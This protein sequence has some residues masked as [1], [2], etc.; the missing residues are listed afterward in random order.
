MTTILTD[1]AQ[2]VTVPDMIP[3][4]DGK[5]APD[6][7]SAQKHIRKIDNFADNEDT[8][9]NVIKWV[10]AYLYKFK[11]QGARQEN[12]HD[13]DRA[14]E[15][16]RASANRSSLDSDQSANIEKTT[17]KIQSATYYSDI[18]AITANEKIVV[19]GNEQIIPVKFEPIPGCPDYGSG[20]QAEAEGERLSKYHNALLAY[21]WEV[22][23]LDR[24]IAN[25]LWRMN[26]YGNVPMEMVWDYKVEERHIKKPKFKRK[27]LGLGSEDRTQ[28]TGF[29]WHKEDVT[30]ADWPRLVVYDMKDVWFDAM[31]DDMQDQS[32]II[33][34]F[35]KQLS[36]VWTMQKTGQFMNVGDIKNGHLY[37]GEQI[38][39]V[40]SDRQAN[41]NES[42][43]SE[44]P[45]TLV[46]IWKCWIRLPVDPETG[47]WD[48]EKNLCTWF[49]CHFA[50]YLDKGNLVCLEIRPNPHSCGLIP[51]NLAH[52]LEDDKGAFHL[53]Y[54]TLGKSYYAQEMTLID[55]ANDNVRE[56][57]RVPLLVEKGSLDIKNLVF[58]P[59]GNRIWPYKSGSKE[60]TELKIQ[61]TT[62]TTIPMLAATEERRQ[63]IM[64]TNKAF[65]GEPIGGR[66]SA[67]GYLGTLDQALKPALE[68]VKFKAEQI[69]PFV[70]FWVKELYYDFGNP[71]TTLLITYEN[72]QLEVKPSYLYGDF[73]IRVSSVKNFQDSAIKR[74]QENELLGQVLPVAA[75]LGAIDAQGSKIIFKQI[76]QDRKIEHLNE[77]FK[78]QGDFDAVRVARSE[79]MAILWQGIFDMPKPEENHAVHLKEHESYLSTV[80]LL[81]DGSRPDDVAI[82]RMKMHIQMH[83]NY[84]S[85]PQGGQGG[86]QPNQASLNQPAPATTPGE[87]SGDQLSGDMGNMGNLQ[88]PDMGGGP[89]TGRPPEYQGMM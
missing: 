54:C 25:A 10:Q 49:R 55:M 18:R 82:Q 66:Q 83:K 68:D 39:P 71:E 5:Y 26:K 23:K 9:A 46:D 12:E 14:D 29:T 45:N 64:G 32:C 19:L 16:Y 8:V 78:T 21:V 11:D 75:Q 60:P 20:D 59:G 47:K 73:R 86:G 69:L 37:F 33:T 84:A 65:L 80:V 38:N 2:A 48:P 1:G 43:D 3:I 76:F 53:S 56:R 17:S 34:R 67:S 44:S 28:I 57:N 30:M 13:M 4:P 79:N 81:P 27:L 70:A 41:A 74:K 42:Q 40:E 52:A 31:I 85:N 89:D 36:E 50:G 63:K 51:F 62:S 87:V 61:D 6:A 35:Q 7:D 88:K 77:I 58:A 22:A 24:T 15:L 72:E